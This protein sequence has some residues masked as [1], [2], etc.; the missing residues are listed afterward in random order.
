MIFLAEFFF[1]KK[2]V[3]TLTTQATYICNFS[4][5]NNLMTFHHYWN[6]WGISSSLIY[7]NEKPLQGINWCTVCYMQIMCIPRKLYC[8]QCACIGLGTHFLRSEALRCCYIHSVDSSEKL[9]QLWDFP[10][11]WVSGVQA[12]W[13]NNCLN[14]HLCIAVF[15]LSEVSLTSLCVLPILLEAVLIFCTDGLCFSIHGSMSLS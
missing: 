15:F 11:Y 2:N 7:K 8:L 4:S 6:S 3:Y 10:R 13:I 12:N 14:W 1:D 9:I 5:G